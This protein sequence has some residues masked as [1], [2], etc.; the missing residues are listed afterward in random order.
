M[1]DEP[2]GPGAVALGWWSKHIAPR[3][4]PAAKALS[5]RL[6]RAAPLAVL[7]EPAVQDLARGLNIGPGQAERLVQLAVLL[8]EVRETGPERLARRLG[9]PEPVLSA[10][11][12]QRLIR[13]EGDELTDLLRR[14][15]SMAERKCNV[16][17]LAADILHWEAAR[18]RWCFDYFGADAPAKDLEEQTR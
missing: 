11:R 10:L 3:E 13:A 5:A 4:T 2:K 17:A 15:I 18:P 7:C 6:R 12:F 16:A 8:A 14:A 9:G 1:S